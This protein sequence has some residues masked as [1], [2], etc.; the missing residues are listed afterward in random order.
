M[1]I[2]YLIYVAN[3]LDVL[4]DKLVC[5]DWLY[6]RAV[7]REELIAA[8]QWRINTCALVLRKSTGKFCTCFRPLKACHHSIPSVFSLALQ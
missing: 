8:K 6:I 1:N 5:A 4:K 2:Q 7:D 3:V